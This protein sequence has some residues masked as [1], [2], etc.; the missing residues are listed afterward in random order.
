MIHIVKIIGCILALTVVLYLQGC[1]IKINCKEVGA[2]NMYA[3][4]VETEE[5]AI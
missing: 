3:E 2:I 1:T 4:E 5:T